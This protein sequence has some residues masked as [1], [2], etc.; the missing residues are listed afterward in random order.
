MARTEPIGRTRRGKSRGRG[1]SQVPSGRSTD[2]GLEEEVDLLRAEP[3]DVETTYQANLKR[4]EALQKEVDD[5]QVLEDIRQ[6]ELRLAQSQNSEVPTRTLGPTPVGVIPVIGEASDQGIRHARGISGDLMLSDPRSIKRTRYRA[7]PDYSGKSRIE[8]HKYL[9]QCEIV[10]QIDAH[11]YVTDASKILLARQYLMGPPHDD[12]NR[13]AKTKV[14]PTWADFKECLEESL[15]DPAMER[16]EAFDEYLKLQQ[17]RGQTAL[18]YLRKL[19]DQLPK[20]DDDARRPE[21]LLMKFRLGL[22]PSNKDR[23][24]LLPPKNNYNVD[25]QAAW[26]TR[27]ERTNLG[28]LSQYQSQGQTVTTRESH[29]ATVQSAGPNQSKSTNPSPG[30]P[31]GRVRVS[32]EEVQRRRTTGLCLKCGGNNHRA[33]T[34]FKGWTLPGSN[35]NPRATP[36]T[37]PNQD[38]LG[39]RQRK[40]PSSANILASLSIRTKRTPVEGDGPEK[41]SP[42]LMEVQCEVRAKSGEWVP[43]VGMT[44]DACQLNV[45]RQFLVKEL[46]LQSGN[47]GPQAVNFDGRPLPIYGTL[48][49]HVR[50]QDSKGR[51]LQV[52]ESFT[53]VQ[54]APRDIVL[55]LPF[56]ERH[57]PIR[58]YKQREIIWRGRSQVHAV[59]E[60][61]KALTPWKSE[62]VLRGF[63]AGAY[64]VLLPPSNVEPEYITVDV[65]T[66]YEDL[67]DVF[68]KAEN[69]TLPDHGPYDHAIDLEPGRTPPF[70]PLYNLSATELSTLRE[71]LERN[72]QKGMIRHSISPAA[73]PL[74]FTPKKDGGLRP[75][76]DYRSLN[77]M[78]IKNRY[79]LPLITEALDRLQGAQ[80]FTKLDV[81]DAY[82][83][84]RIKDGD[85]WKTAFRTRF[86]L[87]EYLVLPF[88]LTNAPASFQS[89]IN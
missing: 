16:Q 65:P 54:D 39:S 12:W 84:I 60:V 46:G 79:P 70:G 41:A 34:C 74:L 6:L 57:N 24:A 35:Q 10:F 26:V 61:P 68:G 21:A 15:G 56:L 49:L 37:N 85:E 40:E 5:A 17:Q 88:G 82:N 75:C 58:N 9:E 27:N 29:I 13:I 31:S 3:G 8:L 23:L 52:K 44:D 1:L 86:G 43:R 36:A 25:E 71:Y 11:N 63:L 87:F 76:V 4:R 62:P 2:L 7:P 51:V 50:V 48:S 53:A 78:T 33:A 59:S 38:Q 28:T 19:K 77:D 83:R 30:P 81:K 47:P 67:S 66:E 42:P 22:L 20:L 72:L 73:S 80:I 18:E 69:L 55:G 32:D 64:A 45:V 89:Y 14:A